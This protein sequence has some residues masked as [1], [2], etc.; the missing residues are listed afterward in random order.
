MWV[1]LWREKT[2]CSKLSILLSLFVSG[3]WDGSQLKHFKLGKTGNL[4]R[5]KYALK[6][7]T[8][9]HTKLSKTLPINVYPQLKIL[10]ARNIR[11]T[12]KRAS[13]I[14]TQTNK[15]EWWKI[16]RFSKRRSK[17]SLK[18]LFKW[19]FGIHFKS[20]FSQN[21][22][23]LSDSHGDSVICILCLDFARF[24]IQNVSVRV[25]NSRI[26]PL[27]LSSFNN[28]CVTKATQQKAF[29]YS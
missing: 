20:K 17:G 19:E 27:E 28:H 6:S 22:L 5:H 24:A 29:L 15:P 2:A 25:H 10:H 7:A 14:I 4:K 26:T 16:W 13:D 23:M 1:P 12:L 11:V 8:A 18:Q 21:T 3:K 9:T